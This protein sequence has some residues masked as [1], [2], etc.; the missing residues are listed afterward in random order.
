MEIKMP[1]LFWGILRDNHPMTAGHCPCYTT[2]CSDKYGE[3]VSSLKF[4]VTGTSPAN[5]L[6]LF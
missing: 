3:L 2:Y 4:V 1:Q 6:E 5:T